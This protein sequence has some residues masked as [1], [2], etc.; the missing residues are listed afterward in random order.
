MISTMSTRFP[1]VPWSSEAQHLIPSLD[2][3]SHLT[4]SYLPA[5][6]SLKYHGKSPRKTHDFWGRIF[7][8]DPEVAQEQN[9]EERKKMIFLNDL[10]QHGLNDVDQLS[11]AVQF[12]KRAV[13][14]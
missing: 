3:Y 11:P 4:R 2:Q 14:L 13:P 1:S 10:K 7:Y 12:G 8:T 9:T 5:K 6:W